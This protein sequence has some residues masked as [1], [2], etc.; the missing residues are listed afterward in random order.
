M[1]NK[2]TLYRLKANGRTVYYNFSKLFIFFFAVYTIALPIFTGYILWHFFLN[3]RERIVL[4]T[5][6]KYQ[7]EH[8]ISLENELQRFVAYIDYL[9]QQGN[10][11]L[12]EVYENSTIDIENLLHESETVLPAIGEHA[13]NQQVQTVPQEEIFSENNENST[14]I[15]TDGSNFDVLSTNEQETLVIPDE[16]SNEIIDE[17]VIISEVEAVAPISLGVLLDERRVEPRNLTLRRNSA[18]SATIRFDLYNTQTGVQIAGD[19]EFTLIKAEDLS[20]VALNSSEYTNYQISNMKNIATNLSPQ[21]GTIDSEDVI[22]LDIYLDDT[23]VYTQII[24]LAQ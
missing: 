9:D 17:D 15:I 10:D 23:I 24:P 19:C 6:L 22:R 3:T 1:S 16:T 8:I 20:E 7:D 5:E 4:E 12:L 11:S 2:I 21:S 18:S 13:Q 14:A